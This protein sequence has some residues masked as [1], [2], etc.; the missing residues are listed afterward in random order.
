MAA[1]GLMTF[2]LMSPHLVLKL[3]TYLPWILHLT[4]FERFMLQFLEWYPFLIIP[5]YLLLLEIALMRML[6]ALSLILFHSLHASDHWS[7]ISDGFRF[8]TRG[9]LLG[10][11]FITIMPWV[12][13]S[14]IHAGGVLDHIGLLRNRSSHPCQ[15]TSPGLT[16]ILCLLSCC[17]YI[18]VMQLFSPPSLGRAPHN[19]YALKLGA[20]QSGYALFPT[21]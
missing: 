15:V 3:L 10:R 14:I 17:I 5:F 21:F 9:E 12:F 11:L 13:C 18:N 20:P 6:L 1:S 4:F 16:L 8:L 19:G 7:L 2:L